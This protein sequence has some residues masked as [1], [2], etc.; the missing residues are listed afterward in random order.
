MSSKM[1]WAVE[2][3]ILMRQAVSKT[4]ALVIERVSS[5][6]DVVVKTYTAGLLTAT[7]VPMQY[8]DAVNYVSTWPDLYI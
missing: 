2:S 1:L 7:T 6:G 3:N 4:T 5:N 8:R